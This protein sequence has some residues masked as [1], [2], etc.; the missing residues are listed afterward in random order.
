M[1]GGIAVAALAAVEPLAWPGGMDEARLPRF[2][3]YDRGRVDGTE[4]GTEAGRRGVPVHALD[5]DPGGPWMRTIEPRLRRGPVALAGL[6]PGPALFCIEFL[7]RDYGLRPVY[8]IEHAAD[9]TGRIRHR[10]TGP[11]DLAS[12]LDFIEA[13]GDGWSTAAAALAAVYPASRRGEAGVPLLD[14]GPSAR[15]APAP[16]FSW[17]IAPAVARAPLT[18]Q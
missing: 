10:P 18:R 8:R 4:F 13:A 7:A 3:V 17:L 2:A 1:K 15:T 12:W 16:L 14:L 6:T 9:T 11:R 5:S